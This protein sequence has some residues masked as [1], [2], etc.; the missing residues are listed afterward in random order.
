M[1]SSHSATPQ[2]TCHTL[3]LR[4]ECACVE[5]MTFDEIFALVASQP[6]SARCEILTRES[7][8]ANDSALHLCV[9]VCVCAESLPD[10]I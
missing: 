3:L 5:F 1:M 10:G 2:F 7:A 8:P 6:S 4:H 9:H